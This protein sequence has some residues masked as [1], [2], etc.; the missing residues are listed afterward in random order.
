MKT[1]QLNNR[2][3]WNRSITDHIIKYRTSEKHHRWRCCYRTGFCCY[4][5]FSGSW[6]ELCGCSCNFSCRLNVG[7]HSR[8]GDNWNRCWCSLSGGYGEFSCY[9]SWDSDGGQSA[10]RCGHCYGSWSDDTCRTLSS[11]EDVDGYVTDPSKQT[12]SEDVGTQSSSKLSVTCLMLRFLHWR[13]NLRIRHFSWRFH[14][15]PVPFGTRWIVR[16]VKGN[17]NN[18]QRYQ[19]E[20]QPH[21]DAAKKVPAQFSPRTQVAMDAF[22]QLHLFHQFD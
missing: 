19:T 18:Q 17:R 10:C 1:F 2:L 12:A 8:C 11:N 21:G 7:R 9:W 4:L 15:V 3:Y 20:Y 14:Q 16:S 5:N 13:L 6:N 22:E